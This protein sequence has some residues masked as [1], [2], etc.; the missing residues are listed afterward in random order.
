MKGIQYVLGRSEKYL[1]FLAGDSLQ[2]VLL[3]GLARG[4]GMYS[5]R[6]CEQDFGKTKPVSLVKQEKRVF[7]EKFGKIYTCTKNHLLSRCTTGKVEQ[8]LRHYMLT[9]FH[10]IPVITTEKCFKDMDQ[11]MTKC[12]LV[13]LIINIAMNSTISA[14]WLPYYI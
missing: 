13:N 11:T 10:T 8:S 9:S 6:F 1:G 2:Q 4:N 3:Q 7:L 12:S 14:E 5:F